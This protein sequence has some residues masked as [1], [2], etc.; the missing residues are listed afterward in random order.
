MASKYTGLTLHD[1]E[2]EMKRTEEE[3][4]TWMIQKRY[5]LPLNLP[6]VQISQIVHSYYQYQLWYV[7]DFAYE[8]LN[9]YLIDL[10]TNHSLY[11]THLVKGSP[12]SPAV[13]VRCSIIRTSWE[14]IK[15]ELLL[16]FAGGT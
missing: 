14:R 16:I 12:P 6:W 11:I 1:E 13:S 10:Y 2:L 15:A 4:P 3:T 8:W 5:K 9:I 7:I